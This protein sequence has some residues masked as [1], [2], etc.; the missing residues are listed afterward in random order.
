MQY[1]KFENGF[2]VFPEG[3]K[4]TVDES[5][6]LSKDATLTNQDIEC[7]NLV[8]KIFDGMVLT[9]NETFYDKRIKPQF[10]KYKNTLHKAIKDEISRIGDSFGPPPILSD[11]ALTKNPEADENYSD[12]QMNIFE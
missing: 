5:L 1:P 12:L 7:I 6:F 10:H 9:G 8:K 3:V 11:S 2:I 4:Y